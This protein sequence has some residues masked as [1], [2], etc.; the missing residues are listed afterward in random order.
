MKGES[1]RTS[2]SLFRSWFCGVLDAC[3]GHPLLL[4]SILCGREDTL[5]SWVEVPWPGLL[6]RSLSA[7]TS[8][9]LTLIRG[10]WWPSQLGK[11]TSSNTFLHPTMESTVWGFMVTT[12]RSKLST[13]PTSQRVTMHGN[14]SIGSKESCGD[15]TCLTL[16]YQV[17]LQNQ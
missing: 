7:L 11:L 5:D 10:R 3:P 16:F 4:R 1:S 6:S 9:I 2:P 13:M 15:E 8:Q 12:L 17:F 14:H